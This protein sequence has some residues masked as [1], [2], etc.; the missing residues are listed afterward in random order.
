MLLERLGF[1]RF[2][3]CKLITQLLCILV[4]S[5]PHRC[6]AREAE[7]EVQMTDPSRAFNK[8]LVF[9]QSDVNRLFE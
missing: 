7:S 5:R 8:Q 9:I 4:I 6:S 2:S 1:L 3:T